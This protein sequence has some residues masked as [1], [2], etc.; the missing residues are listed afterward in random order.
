VDDYLHYNQTPV[1]ELKCA[2][3]EN[4]SVELYVKR[5]DLNHPSVAGNKWWK[6]KYNML[7]A[8]EKNFST[9]LTFG[10]AYSNHLYATS[11]A[12]REL[13]FKSIGI[14]RGEEYMPLN[15]TLTF[16]QQNGMKLHYVNRETYKKKQEQSFLDSLKEKFGDV[17]IIPEGG[18]NL[19]AI[20]GCAEFGTILNEIDS[21][22]VMLPVG[23]AGTISGLIPSLPVSRRIIGVPVFKNGEFLQREIS[24]WVE[25]YSGETFHHWSLLLNYHHGGYAKTSPELLDF[26]HGVR[27]DFGLPLDHVY[28][29]KLLFAIFEEIKRGAFPR[30]S[31]ILMIHTGGLQGSMN[32]SDKHERGSD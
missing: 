5:E 13:G 27:N 18:T 17:Y 20:K 29:G 32:V 25:K 23:T 11:A 2:L 30:G 26:I 9:V 10:G 12:A 16:A 3:L 28:T 4:H 7:D 1:V 21:D 24:D 6:L 15:P 22:Y 31:K 14:V 8:K 19:L